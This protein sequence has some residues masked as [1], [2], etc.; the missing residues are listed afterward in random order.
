M[1]TFQLWRSGRPQDG[2][3]TQERNSDPELSQGD[4]FGKASKKQGLGQAV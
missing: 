1:N 4:E 3:W 2:D